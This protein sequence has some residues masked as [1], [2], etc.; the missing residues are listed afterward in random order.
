MP[1]DE[2][3]LHDYFRTALHRS[4]CDRLGI[5][6]EA[7]ETYL[8]AMLVRMAANDGLYAV[9]DAGGR[10]VATVLEM[11]AY[12][13]VRLKAD[14]FDQERRVHRHV[15]DFVLFWAGLFPERLA[16]LRGPLLDPIAQGR[17]SYA[18]AASFDHPPYHEEAPVL[19]RLASEFETFR[20]G[21]S[22]VREGF[23]AAQ[24]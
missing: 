12:G 23:G 6:D 4:L 9:R 8:A 5:D 11:L 22:L 7:V 13:D 18:I 21:L 16:V 17:E 3:S 14:S 2:L 1:K 10:P 19:G 15:G 20:E 24:P